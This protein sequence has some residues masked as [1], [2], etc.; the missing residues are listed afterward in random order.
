MSNNDTSSLVA[1]Q[2]RTTQAVRA[3][4]VFFLY[5]ALFNL[6]GGVIIGIAYVS[7]FG[8][9]SGLSSASGGIVFGGLVIA[10]GSIF[11]LFKGLSELGKSAIDSTGNVSSVS[12]GATYGAEAKSAPAE[13]QVSC[14]NCGTPN[15]WNQ[16]RCSS[17]D[18]LVE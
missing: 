7:S 3:I 13:G 4:A 12:S 2:N 15:P 8:S 10:G 9:Y 14:K 11:A 17:C 18:G 1:A 6:I 5:S 16:L